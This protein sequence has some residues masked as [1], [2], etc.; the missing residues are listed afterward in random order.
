MARHREAAARST[1]P[2]YHR[3]PGL[4]ACCGPAGGGGPHGCSASTPSFGRYG[5]SGPVDLRRTGATVVVVVVPDA[6]VLLKWVVAGDDEPDTGATGAALSLRDE[7]VSG[8]IELLVPQLWIY[9]V[10]N[11]LARRFPEQSDELLAS[12]V[13]RMFSRRVSYKALPKTVKCVKELILKGLRG[14]FGC[15]ELIPCTIRAWNSA[16]EKALRGRIRTDGARVPVEVQRLTESGLAPVGQ[17][18]VARPTA[19]ATLGGSAASPW[20]RG[21]RRAS[22]SPAS[23]RTGLAR[24]EPRD[25]PIHG[26]PIRRHRSVD[27]M[28]RLRDYDARENRWILD[29]VWPQI[30]VAD[31]APGSETAG[32]VKERRRRRRRE[33]EVIRRDRFPKRAGR[34]AARDECVAGA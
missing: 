6:S 20:C 33:N 12:L 29:P 34:S 4:V 13:E 31:C 9:E 15:R 18:R 22:R 16:D 24:P 11:T 21:G 17:A 3:D 5:R 32:F 19:G 1:L 23:T 2:R 26:L 25:D 27:Q 10:G 30:I 14:V 7:A 8:T 28:V